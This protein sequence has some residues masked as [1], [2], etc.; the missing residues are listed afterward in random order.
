MPSATRS[1][2]C[3]RQQGQTGHLPRGKPLELSIRLGERP[4]AKAVSEQPAEEPEQVLGLEVE[5]LTKEL[6][7]RFHYKVGDGVIV[8]G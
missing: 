8:S 4:T 2:C 6:A 5:D 1:P 7:D 3:H